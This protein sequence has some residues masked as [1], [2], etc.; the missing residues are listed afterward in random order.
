MRVIF[1]FSKKI[2]LLLVSLC[3]LTLVVI[4]TISL[5]IMEE[6][7]TA[8]VTDNLKKLTQSTYNQVDSAVNTSIKNYLRAIAEKNLD[9][10]NLIYSQFQSGEL[11]ETEAYELVN[12]LMM[13]Q[14]IGETGYIYVVDS[15]GA[16]QVQPFLK[17]ENLKEYSYIKEQ[18]KQK[19]GYLEYLWKN[20]DD[21]VEREKILYMTYFEPWD[22]IIAVSSYKSDLNELVHIDDFRENILS[23]SLGE[24]G[25]IYVLDSTGKLIIHPKQEGLNIIDS[26]DSK[27]HYF[28]Q[29]IISSKTGSI[30][31]PW[32]NPGEIGKRDKIV[33]YDYYEP[34]DWY[35]C[36]GVYI[37]ELTAP[38]KQLKLRIFYVALGLLLLTMMISWIY[39]QLILKPIRELILAMNGAKKG[40]YDHHINLARNDEI[41]QLATIYDEMITKI[42]LDTEALELSNMTLEFKVKERTHQLEMLSNQDAL[43]GISNRRKLDNFL[44]FQLQLCQ[45]TGLP[46]S[47]IMI[48]ID[49]FKRYNDI[50]GHPKG[51]DCLIAIAKTIE[52]LLH[53]AT[54]L[55]GRYGGEEFV[56]VLPNTDGLGAVKVAQNIGIALE[57]LAV[58]HASSDVSSF[59]TAS[60]GIVT[61][62]EVS[63][64]SILSLYNRA[65]EALYA[66]KKNGRNQYQCYVNEDRILPFASTS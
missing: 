57:D 30:V 37:E 42:K 25:Y 36:S 28:I 60:M 43:T 24:T 10:I 5:S 29:E 40:Y 56:V 16:L 13:S 33:V 18:I 31:Y 32:N 64:C 52:H 14:S 45:R 19:Q 65:D 9:M 1:G 50:Y 34:M 63:D 6:M 3:I 47:M 39:S 20:P 8:Q 21:A 46:I 49:Y 61:E 48:D 44:E 27:G 4:S 51:D 2:M 7:N 35:I 59:V 53:R 17:G 12:Q 66:A 58:E 54:D 62:S 41:G 55:V 23:I 11:S 22:Y 26:V 38:F 15:S